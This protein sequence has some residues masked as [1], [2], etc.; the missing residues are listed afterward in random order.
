[1][2]IGAPD[3]VLTLDLGTERR[4]TSPAAL[5]PCSPAALQVH[6]SEAVTVYASRI[7]ASLTFDWMA[8]AHTLLVLYS[9]N[10]ATGGWSMGGAVQSAPGAPTSLNLTD[11]GANAAAGVRAR[12]LRLYLADP[13]V[14][15]APSPNGTVPM[16]QTP[17]PPPPP[18][19]P[20][21][22]PQQPRYPPSPSLPMLA[23]RELG[24]S[25]CALSEAAVGAACLTMPSRGRHSSPPWPPEAGSGRRACTLWRRSR[26]LRRAQR[27]GAA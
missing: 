17:S 14:Y 19:P 3:A 4:V 7:V 13:S 6:V 11:G 1:M 27:E 12:F 22:A 25:S 26:V 15:V 18:L 21:L 23:L 2:S 9:L 8:P 10:P 16:T 24:V 20:P 5:Q